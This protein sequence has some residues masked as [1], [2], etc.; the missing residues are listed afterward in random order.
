MPKKINMLYI[1]SEEYTT[2]IQFTILIFGWQA[3]NDKHW[4]SSLMGAL[5]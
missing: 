5:K 1:A 2:F 3:R 4:C